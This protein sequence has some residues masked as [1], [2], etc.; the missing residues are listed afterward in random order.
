MIMIQFQNK[1]LKALVCAANVK[2]RK[3]LLK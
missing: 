3:R 1:K 2:T